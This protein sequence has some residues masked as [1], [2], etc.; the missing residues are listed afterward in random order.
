MEK[1]REFSVEQGIDIQQ[2]QL[3]RWKVVLNEDA[4]K[5]LCEVCD[6]RNAMPMRNG[7]DVIRGQE[8]DTIVYNY[9]SAIVNGYGVR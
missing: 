1:E 6:E 2:G 9:G 5:Y 8:L 7:F 3:K 4:Y